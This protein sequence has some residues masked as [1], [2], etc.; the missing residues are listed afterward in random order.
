MY[1]EIIRNN[2]K[3]NQIK[4]D[5]STLSIIRNTNN[6]KH[7]IFKK[8][9]KEIENN[10]STEYRINEPSISNHNEELLDR[11]LDEVMLLIDAFSNLKITESINQSKKL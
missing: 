1:I 9:L 8:K 5:N 2:N 10:Y 3:P 4:F 6:A 7:I 11:C